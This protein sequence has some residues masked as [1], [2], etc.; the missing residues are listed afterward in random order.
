MS[1]K[2]RWTKAEE[3]VLVAQ[4]AHTP[5]VDIAFALGR[6]D[7]STEQ[8]AT[9][10][11]LRKAMRQI[12]DDEVRRLHA[13]GFSNPQIH[14]AIGF[15]PETIDASLRRLGLTRHTKYLGVK[16]LARLAE[17]WG[18]SIE[19][20]EE[21]RAKRLTH[22]YLCHRKGAQERGIGWELTRP[23]WLRI[24][25][26]SGKL[27]LRGTGSGRYCMSRFGDVGPYAVDNVEIKLSLVNLRE[28][29]AC[30]GRNGQFPRGI[31]KPFPGSAKPFRAV[32]NKKRLGRFATVEE[33][34]AAMQRD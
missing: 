6:T 14:A 22:A 21:I 20:G 30:R 12:D 31:S 5:T 16:R 10:M 25:K 7:R 4:Y 15:D 13:Q 9:R 32:L 29:V 28:G 18:V 8:K 11:G 1:H 17:A 34:L 24:W 19:E 33:A 23:E 27:D 26:Q 3:A 2:P